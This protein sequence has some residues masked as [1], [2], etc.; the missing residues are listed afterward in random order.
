MRVE[1]LVGLLLVAAVPARSQDLGE[2]IVVTATRAPETTATTPAQVVVVPGKQIEQA[3]AVDEALRADPSFQTFRRN[4]SLVADP[5]SQGANLRGIGPSGVSRAL[6]LEDGVPVND[7]FGGWIYWGSI[8]RLG[9]ERVEIA[10]GISSALY[11]S[12]ALGG[13]VQVISRPIE[14]RADVEVQGGRYGTAQGDLSLAGRGGAFG[15]ALDAEGLT[16]GGYG[17]VDQPGAVDHPASSRHVS[18]RGRFEAK[19]APDLTATARLEGFAEDQDGGTQYTTAAAREVLAALGL[20]AGTLT[21]RAFARWARFDQQR[22]RVA[23]DRSSETLASTQSAP[24]DDEGL[25]VQW[26]HGGFMLG[27]DAHR[28]FGRS[29]EHPATGAI[30][31]RETPG[32]QRMVGAFAEEVVDPLSWLRV[33]AALRVDYWHNLGGVR[34][35]TLR[36]GGAQ[37]SDQPDRSDTAL[38]P[39]IALRAQA[40]PWLSFHGAAYRAFRAP[41]LNEL[42][43]PFQVG[44]TVTAANPLLGP[45]TL[46][47]A[48]AGFETRWARAT[49]F[50]AGLRDPITNVTVAPGQQQRQNLGSARIL[51]VEA[52]ARW[53]PVT[54]VRLSLAYTFT[55]AAVTSG[56]LTGKTLPQDPRHRIAAAARFDDARWATVEVAV[57]WMSDQY[58]DDQNTLRLPG[59]AVIDASISRA[60]GDRWEVFLAA[61]NL[62]DRRYLVGLQGVA[63]IGQPLFVRAGARA[64]LF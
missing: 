48:E 33:Q 28:V 42:Y 20:D 36:A 57:R 49:F 52:E 63:T 16:T 1:S 45:E 15:A 58:D 13:V 29:I 21:A 46:N 38:S 51:G 64:R 60:F 26:S 61:E 4:S 2:D 41:T 40:L 59:F 19:L 14:D 35:E 25:S 3:K 56:N 24:A 39:R 53:S 32:E 62:L 50:A 47:G 5:S 34:H 10:P 18:G 31:S 8:P 11:G 43:R 54:P 30:A 37:D 44:A 22:A 27:A 9:I 7:G 12:S 23:P 55:D 6:V 17:V